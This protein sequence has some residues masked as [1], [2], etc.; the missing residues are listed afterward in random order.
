MLKALLIIL[1]FIASSVVANETKH[2]PIV[3]QR[4][5]GFTDLIADG[6]QVHWQGLLAEPYDKPHQRNQLSHK[7]KAKKQITADQIMNA[8]WQLED[9]ILYFDGNGT[10]LA[11][12]KYYGDFELYLDWKI[13]KNGD[14]GVYLRGL[15]QVQIWDP[16]NPEVNKYGAPKG[17]GGLWNNTNKGKFPIVKAII[18]LVNGTSFI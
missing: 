8:H 6:V 1:V 16:D 3:E 15:P 17:S 14:S 10:S 13:E 2:L 12:K 11:T 5:A 4:P 18:P 7:D 9:N